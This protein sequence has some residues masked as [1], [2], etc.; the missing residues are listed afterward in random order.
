MYNH[1]SLTDYLFLFD[2][3]NEIKTNIHLI[4]NRKIILLSF[5]SV[6][7]LFYISYHTK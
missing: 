7:F 1:C 3:C 6:V 5:K 4:F 2:A